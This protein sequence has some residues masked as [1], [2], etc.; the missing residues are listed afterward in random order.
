MFVWLC[1]FVCACACVFVCVCV[2]LF[3]CVCLLCV[4]VPVRMP[5]C[6]CTLTLPSSTAASL[7]FFA[8]ILSASLLSVAFA[9]VSHIVLPLAFLSDESLMAKYMISKDS[10][11]L[12]HGSAT[13]CQSD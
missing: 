4:S 5:V 8:S 12:V 11:G 13:V 2:C 9:P 1:V 7:P 3:V 6:L 10:R